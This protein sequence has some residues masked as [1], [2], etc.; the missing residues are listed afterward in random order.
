MESN[1]DIINKIMD[2]INE[3]NGDNDNLIE[4]NHKNKK[5]QL[6]YFE[7]KKATIEK[8]SFVLNGTLY[9]EDK[10][11]YIC[12]NISDAIYKKYENYSQILLDENRKTKEYLFE[13][14]T[15][16]AFSDFKLFAIKSGLGL[17][18]T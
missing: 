15:Q 3:N 16:V 11:Y 6:F 17:H 9:T 13:Q 18:L 10:K 12:F 4:F 5:L 1:K 2:F 7:E 14:K 8:V